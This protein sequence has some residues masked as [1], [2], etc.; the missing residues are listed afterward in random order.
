MESLSHAGGVPDPEALLKGSRAG[1]FSVVGYRLRCLVRGR[2]AELVAAGLLSVMAVNLLSVIAQ[3]SITIDESLAIPAGYYYLTA[4]AFHIDNDHPPLPKM[5]AALPLLF[6]SVQ[7]PSL[8]ELGNE[9]SAQQTLT[10]GARFWSANRDQFETIFFW[11]RVPMIILTLLLGALVFTFTRRLFNAR[12]AALAVALFSLEPTILAHGRVVKDIHVA[13][14]YL[15]FFF[16]L[17]VYWS[18]PTLRRAILLGL[19]CGLALAV[20]YS[21]VILFPIL[22]VSGCVPMLRSPPGAQRRRIVFQ[23]II[24]AFAALLALNAAYFFR[25]QPLSVNDLKSLAHNAPAYSSVMLSLLKLFSVFAPPY[26]LLGAFDTFM[27]NDLGHPGFLLGEYSEHGWWYYFPVAFALKTTIPFLLL[28]IVSVAWAVRRAF[29]RDVKFL[30]LLAPVVIYAVP[31]ML[32]GINIG[33]RH[34]LPVFPF[35]FILGA[36]Y[37]TAC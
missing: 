12:A 28:T 1:M 9:A 17:Y 16:A 34:F 14:A 26:F 20:K 35:F 18:A 22:L 37:W 5:L 11:A 6:F 30:L 3:K 32:A 25:H 36:R 10:A 21:M 8:D 15:L 2:V 29:R 4:Q 7:A 13:F 23:I 33:I 31:A 19:A 27:H 24:S